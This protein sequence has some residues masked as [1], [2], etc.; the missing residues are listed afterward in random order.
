[1]D[2]SRVDPRVGSGRVAGRVAGEILGK[3][4]KSGRNFSNALFISQ[5][6]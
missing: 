1:M 2:T 4:G 5:V 3:F 6:K